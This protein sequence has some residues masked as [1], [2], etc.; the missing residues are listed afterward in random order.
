MVKNKMSRFLW[1]TVYINIVYYYSLTTHFS[2]HACM[3]IDNISHLFLRAYWTILY[4]IQERQATIAAQQVCVIFQ[5]K[6]CNL[7]PQRYDA[8]RDLK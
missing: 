1:F 8:T 5:T 4:Q 7:K 6:H 3:K 2:L